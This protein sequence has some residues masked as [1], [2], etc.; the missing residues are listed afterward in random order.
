VLGDYLAGLGDAKPIRDIALLKS[1]AALDH[2]VG[3]LVTSASED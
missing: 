1:V 2:E 3:G